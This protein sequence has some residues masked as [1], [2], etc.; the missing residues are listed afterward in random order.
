MVGLC[1]RGSGVLVVAVEYRE[2][3]DRLE[4]LN[5]VQAEGGYHPR[6]TSDVRDATRSPETPGHRRVEGDGRKGPRYRAGTVRQLARET[7]R[8][9]GESSL[10]HS[11]RGRGRRYGARASVET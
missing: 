8:R 3:K 4:H 2:R 7:R 11:L 5:P 6:S 9:I 10:G 1:G